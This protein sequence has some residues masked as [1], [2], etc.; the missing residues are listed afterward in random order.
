M[1]S[2]AAML[3]LLIAVACGQSTSQRP[4]PQYTAAVSLPPGPELAALQANCEICHSEDMIS[5]QRLSRA[6]WDA[7]VTKM[8]LFGSPLPKTDQ[9]AVVAYLVRYLGPDVPRVSAVPVV[10]APPISYTSAPSSE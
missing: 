6:T 10:S 9:A 7:E 5:T 3:L 8:V 1:R 2:V 4:Q